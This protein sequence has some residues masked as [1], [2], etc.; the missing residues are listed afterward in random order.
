ML[1]VLNF[2]NV[3]FGLEYL[4]KSSSQVMDNTPW[5]AKRSPSNKQWQ[6]KSYIVVNG[7]QAYYNIYETA[8]NCKKFI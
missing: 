6:A 4:F 5:F 2:F 3:Y 7:R 8:I 1:F